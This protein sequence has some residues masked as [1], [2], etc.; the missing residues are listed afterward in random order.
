MV[1]YDQMKRKKENTLQHASYR[2]LC[3]R[4]FHMFCRLRECSDRET[5]EKKRCTQTF[6]V[7]AIGEDVRG[8]YEDEERRSKMVGNS[9]RK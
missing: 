7:K 2:R 8:H 9:S 4:M 6:A 5:E 1:M 3:N